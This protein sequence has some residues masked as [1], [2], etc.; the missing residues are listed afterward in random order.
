MG[1]SAMTSAL[2]GVSA[3][4][5]MA[6]QRWL[7]ETPRAPGLELLDMA[8]AA[9]SDPPPAP[10][11]EAMARAILEDTDAHLY[12]P[13]L[14]LPALRAEI[15]AQWSAGYGGRIE[16]A[17]VA[18]TAGC[19][20][21]FAAA[22][23]T[24]AAPGDAVL[25]AAPWY[26]NHQMWLDILRVRADALPVDMENAALPSV[27]AA[28]ARL[29]PETTAILLISPNNPTGAE[30]PPELIAE[31]AD[32][33][34]EADVALI[35]DE[36][37]RDFRIG[38]DAPHSLFQR[39]DWRDRLIHLYSFSKTYRLT[40]HR[41]GAM[42]AGAD[43][44][45]ETEKFLDTVTICAPQLGQ[46]AALEG[47][48]TLGD[49]VAAE[50]LDILARGDALRAAAPELPAGWRLISAGAYFAYLEHPYDA[51]SDMIAQEL[52]ARQNLLCLP[53]VMFAPTRAQGGDGWAERTFRM[54]FANAAPAGVREAI[55]RIAA[56]RR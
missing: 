25:I 34:A 51:P 53:G 39:P 14:G 48:R 20:E 28:R 37:Y 23:A 29:T 32:L 16:A 22:V 11:R 55:A 21:A 18:I 9:P 24:V 5:I 3:A 27:A 56:F 2:A 8:Q 10:L 49:W 30:Y 41:V 35:L 12:G 43:R 26:F 47:L 6:A 4:P 31:F 46:I 19:N 54:A 33:A 45:G 7:R 40:G 1:G 52:L 44:L 13:V 50:R 17:D 38:T 42:I 15:A 36:T